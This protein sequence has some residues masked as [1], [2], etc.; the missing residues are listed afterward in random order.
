M[1]EDAHVYNDA[2]MKC[3]ELFHYG[4]TLGYNFTLLD[5]GGGFPGAKGSDNQFELMSAKILET[6]DLLFNFSS[7]PGLKVIAEPGHSFCKKIIII[8]TTFMKH[9]S[10]FL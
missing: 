2:L 10:I 5:I 3:A 4:S 9:S 6:M 7:N 8:L 1:C